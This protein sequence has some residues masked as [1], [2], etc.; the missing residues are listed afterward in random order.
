MRL[1][2]KSF[3]QAVEVAS[4]LKA[5]SNSVF[6]FLLSGGLSN[7][8]YMMPRLFWEARFEAD[9]AAKSG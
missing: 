8:R 3:V 4:F 9:T 6:A 5:R 2:S 1:P 7:D